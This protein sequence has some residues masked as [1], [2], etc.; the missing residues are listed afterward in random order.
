MQQF[1][2]Q[3]LGSALGA[4]GPSGDKVQDHWGMPGNLPRNW[5]GCLMLLGNDEVGGNTRV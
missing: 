3:S 5:R 2:Q 4:S 1:A